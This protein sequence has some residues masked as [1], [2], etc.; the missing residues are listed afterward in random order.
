MNRPAF[1]VFCEDERAA[2]ACFTGHRRLPDDAV[3]QIAAQTLHI[4]D[5]LIG[6]GYRDFLCGGA[7]GYD[8]LAEQCILERKRTSPGI[9][10][11][12]ALPCRDQTERWS[13]LPGEQARDALREYQRIKGL[14]D[15]VIYLRDFYTDG[16]MKERNRYMVERSSF[17]VAYY[18]EGTKGRSGAGQTF[19]LAKEAGL[20]IYNVFDA[21]GRRQ[22]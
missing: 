15:E 3:R 6:A 5:V 17:L 22:S 14:A 20:K 10:L 18:D 21:L 8:T 7:L 4:L 1:P 9:R 11:L 2:T 12:L 13:Y 16:C 19:R